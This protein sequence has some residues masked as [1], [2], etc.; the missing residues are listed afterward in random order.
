MTCSPFLGC[1]ILPIL[2]V[3]K[4]TSEQKP[5]RLLRNWFFS[6]QRGDGCP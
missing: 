1:I 6:A 5:E 3:K 4:A 2:E